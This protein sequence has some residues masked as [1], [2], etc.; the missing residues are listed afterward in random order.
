MSLQ[1]LLANV[2][3]GAAQSYWYRSIV[4]AKGEC[5]GDLRF[6]SVTHG[7]V[8]WRSLS[9]SKLSLTSLEEPYYRGQNTTGLAST[10]LT[11]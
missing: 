4:A 9:G 10:T 2:R 1:T 5:F 6:V 8:L 11:F 3:A 7:L